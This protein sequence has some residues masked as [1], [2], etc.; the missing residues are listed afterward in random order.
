MSRLQEMSGLGGL[1]GGACAS[2]CR[3]GPEIARHGAIRG[4]RY[5][6]PFRINM[7]DLTD[8]TAT[9][10][11]ARAP[12]VIS[13]PPPAKD[14]CGVPRLLMALGGRAAD[15]HPQIRSDTVVLTPHGTL[16]HTRGCWAIHAHRGTTHRYVHYIMHAVVRRRVRCYWSMQITA[17]CSGP[18]ETAPTCGMSY[19]PATAACGMRAAMICKDQQ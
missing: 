13:Q 6:I 5:S 9:S 11:R 15:F 8:H 3:P 4:P 19:G 17:R 14:E 1:E 16:L 10:A 2:T 7:H 18:H 12:R